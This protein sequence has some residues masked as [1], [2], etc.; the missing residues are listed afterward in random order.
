MYKKHLGDACMEF[1]ENMLIYSV[2]SRDPRSKRC[3]QIMGVSTAAIILLG[4]LLSW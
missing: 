4:S 1:H 3:D 2:W